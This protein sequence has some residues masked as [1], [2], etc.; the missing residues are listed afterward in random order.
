MPTYE[1]IERTTDMGWSGRY[2]VERDDSGK[3]TRAYG[4]VYFSNKSADE[5]R[6]LIDEKGSRDIV[7]FLNTPSVN[8]VVDCR[9][10]GY[11]HPAAMHCE[12]G[13]KGEPT[14][15]HSAT[16]NMGG[17]CESCYAK[18]TGW[19]PT[20]APTA[21]QSGKLARMQMRPIQGPKPMMDMQRRVLESRRRI[22]RTP[23]ARLD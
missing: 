22:E 11:H 21:I 3:I 19:R 4:P 2:A 14:C 18:R 13:A 15:P 16:Q 9:T 8:D 20:R 12:G 5:I 6:D 10:C 17:E 7:D 1:V 23:K